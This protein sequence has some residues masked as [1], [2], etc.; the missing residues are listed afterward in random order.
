MTNETTLAIGVDGGASGVR[1]LA[2]RR[3]DDGLLAAAGGIARRDHVPFDAADIV[4]QRAEADDPRHD[5]REIG[6]A[7][8]RR[9]ATVEVVEEAAGDARLVALGLCW[10]GLKTR[11][12]RGVLIMR[13]GPRDPRLLDDIQRDLRER[14]FELARPMPRLGSDGVAGAMGE[15][16]SNTGLLRDARNALYFAGGSGL[17]EAVV[18]DGRVLALDELLQPLPKAFELPYRSSQPWRSSRNDT[19]AR[20]AHFEDVLAPG[21]WSG[22]HAFVAP[23]ATVGF[24]SGR[25]DWIATFRRDPAGAERL[26]DVASSAL[27]GYIQDR[28]RRLR[29]TAG[30]VPDRA[31]VGARLGTLLAHPDLHRVFRDP[32]REGLERAGLSPDFVRG[33]TLLEAPCFGAAA[34]A[35]CLQDEACPS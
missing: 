11:D 35:L 22:P 13:N 16:W 9:I 17:A 7:R 18:V 4:S 33:S 32:V 15:R 31:V 34:L 12:G 26:L 24:P 27:V 3:G 10:P 14:G 30:I 19:K 20:P 8:E 2:V 21:R 29:E 5:E 1:A 28:M 25:V 6:A 23:L